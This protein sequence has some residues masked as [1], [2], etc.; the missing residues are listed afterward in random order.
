V[1]RPTSVE[2]VVVGGIEST[3]WHRTCVA[4]VTCRPPAEDRGTTT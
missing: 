1:H 2:L 4:D 3:R